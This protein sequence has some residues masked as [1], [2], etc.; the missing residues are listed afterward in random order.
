MRSFGSAARSAASRLG[1][2]PRLRS[3][4]WTS[5]AATAAARQVR[6]EHSSASAESKH[7]KSPLHDFHLEHGAKM[8]GF[9]GWMM[10]LQYGGTSL[11]ESHLFTRSH[12]SLFDVSH[13]AQHLF[14]GPRAA[15]FLETVT[16]SAIGSMAPMQS[17]LT[18]LLWPGTGGIVD[19]MVVT[20][21]GS[22]EF[23]AVTNAGNRAKDEQYL[24]EQ[25]AGADGVEWTRLP[26]EGLVALQGPLA[27]EVLRDALASELDLGRLYFG[28]AA[29]ARL[30][31]GDGSACPS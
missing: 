2:A 5:A 29:W 30:R 17:K 26:G 18:T 22:A 27:A 11:T 15:D 21:L 8:V 28:N 6:L 24:E 25:L 13:M 10:P 20:R 12:A 1:Q 9:A 23:H 19:D 3:R 14:R 4:P 31:L 7:S 16:P